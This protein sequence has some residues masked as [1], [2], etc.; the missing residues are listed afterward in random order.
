[1]SP[2]DLTE[3]PI[4][5][6]SAAV[7]FAGLGAEVR[8]DILRMLVRAGSNGMAVGDIQEKSGLAASTLAHHLKAL[9][10]AGVTSQE[11]QGRT[12]LNRANF[13]FLE[14]LAAFILRECCAEEK[15]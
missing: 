11:R 13:E 6:T 15:T 7:A 9:R 8:L 2:K 10:D 1:M 5:V 4:D 3:N 14:A 12:I